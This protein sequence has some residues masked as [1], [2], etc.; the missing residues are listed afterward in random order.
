MSVFNDDR[1]TLNQAATNF[2]SE[3]SSSGLD[4]AL[5]NAFE[6]GMELDEIMYVITTHTEK[7]VRRYIVQHQLKAAASKNK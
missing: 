3:L 7:T 6:A 2:D 1:S 4:A 5:K